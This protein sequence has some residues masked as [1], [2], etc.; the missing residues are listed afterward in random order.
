M[1]FDLYNCNLHITLIQDNSNAIYFSLDFIY[2]KY[3]SARWSQRPFS[4]ES[5][6]LFSW[7]HLQSDGE[8]NIIFCIKYI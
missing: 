5:G 7:R 1:K 6:K 2:I 4:T 3:S 8:I